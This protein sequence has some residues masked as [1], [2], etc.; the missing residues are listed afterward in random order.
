VVATLAADEI[1]WGDATAAPDGSITLV[2]HRQTKGALP[3]GQTM[4]IAA[5]ATPAAIDTALQPVFGSAAPVGG[6]GSGSAGGSAATG[7]GE[8]GTAPPWSREKK[9]GIGLAVGGGTAIV[10]G[11]ALW[12]SESSVQSQI[13]ASRDNTLSEIQAINSLVG[14][15]NGYAWAGNILVLLGLAAG[16]AGA[17]YL[18]MDHKAHITTVAPAPVDHGTGAALVIGGRW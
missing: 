12:T 17:Y 6:S 1:V 7:G 16:G 2:M 10:I 18:W 13:N 15:A 3:Q 9:I 5:N 11:L 14:T 8:P 4:T